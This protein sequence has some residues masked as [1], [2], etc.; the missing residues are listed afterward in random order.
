MLFP[1]GL[2]AAATIFWS[3][4]RYREAKQSGHM[5]YLVF[6]PLQQFWLL[7]IC[8]CF[9]LIHS[10]RYGCTKRESECHLRNANFKSL[11]Y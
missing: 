3:L 10:W 8:V 4:I 2:Y 1:R 6:H 5:T 7:Q 9:D 11:N